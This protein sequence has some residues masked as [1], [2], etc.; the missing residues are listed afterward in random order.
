MDSVSTVVS[1]IAISDDKIQAV[2]DNLEIM[3]LAVKATDRIDLKGKTLIPGLI[4]AHTHLDRA[5]LSE[6]YEVIPAVSTID[7]LLESIEKKAQSLPAGD[8]II[9]P[10]LF[11]TRLEEMHWPTLKEL[12]KVTPGHPV[13]L[14]GSYAA[15]VNSK[16]LEISG[17]EKDESHPGVLKDEK[18]GLPTGSIL[19]SAFP[20]L[21]LPASQSY[22]LEEKQQAM[23]A[24]MQH[25][26]Q[27]G[28][29]SVNI[30][31]T[32]PLD[33]EFYQQLFNSGRSTVRLNLTF[34]QR[35]L[36]IDNSD[37]LDEVRAKIISLG[38]NTGFGNDW[39]RVGPLKWQIDGGILTGTAYLREPW[40]KYHPERVMEVY[41]ISDV[42]FNG[43]PLI[44][45]EKLE[46][47]IALTEE[48]G[49]DFTA[50]CTG[51]G[52]V[53][54][55]LEAY[56]RFRRENP[57][58]KHGFSIIHGNFY[59]QEAIQKMKKLGVSADMQPAWF[60]KDAD[61]MAYLL[62]EKRIKTFHP[63]RSMIEAGVL[64]NGGSDH[65]VKFDSYTAVNPYNPFVAM[66]S[67]IT[68]KTERGSII[69]PEEA[70]SREKALSMYTINN[71][72]LS[73]EG[74]IKGTLEPGK[75]ADMVV[76]SKDLFT[77]KEDEIREIEVEL[78]LV[79]GNIVYQTEW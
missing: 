47:F 14:D 45:Q 1:A 29:T 58:A 3:A 21:S 42:G 53:D 59:T 34:H 74:Q 18:T 19:S 2:G 56:D 76:I 35:D 37:P 40:A 46:S 31:S 23:L 30:R 24:M 36:G 72:I 44:T 60:Y 11:S 4:D 16:A 50:H 9:I 57:N 22:S 8:W 55:M 63:Y 54:L 25:Y 26:N 68:R 39:V 77:C 48:L 27:V 78:T 69:V 5:A 41:G 64:V 71:A 38:Y 66:W 33:L 7:N 75:L 52:G 79:G 12:D 17:I 28:I 13:F 43:V 62:G 49:W 70:V 20:L 65:M 61:A 67:V 6:L 51:G 15:M 73:R 10:K 32:N